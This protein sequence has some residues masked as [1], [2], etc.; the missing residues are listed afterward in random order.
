MATKTRSHPVRW[1]C[2][3]PVRAIAKGRPRFGNGRTF[4][5]EKTVSAE[6]E[7][8]WLLRKHLAPKF[9]GPVHLGLLVTFSKP[10]SAPKKRTHPVVK[11]DIDNVM[12]LF[13]DAANGILWNDDSQICSA[14]LCK[15]YGLDDSIRISV[16]CLPMP[17]S[18]DWPC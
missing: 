5:P 3:L 13:C 14:S 4:T 17:G 15:R 11:P 9:E 7:I 1:D 8:S 6:Q 18:E 12:K 16:Q 2:V 10:K